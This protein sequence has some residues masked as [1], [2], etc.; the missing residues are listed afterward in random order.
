MAVALTECFHY[1]FYR[2]YHVT[3][4]RLFTVTVNGFGLFPLMVISVTITVNLNHTACVFA[5]LW[6]SFFMLPGEED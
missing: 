4:S 5:D 6:Y 1:G 2:Y 3:V